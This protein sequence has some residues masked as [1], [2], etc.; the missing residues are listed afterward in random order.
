VDETLSEEERKHLEAVGAW[1]DENTVTV[2]EPNTVT[3]Y[4]FKVDW[5]KWSGSFRIR[6][7]DVLHEDRFQ[8]S[9]DGTG[10]VRLSLP[11]FVSPLGAPASY[12]A[13]EISERTREAIL[14]ALGSTLPK[15]TPHGRNRK[16]G[17]ET[18]V[19]TPISERLTSD[20]LRKIK[21]VVNFK[22]SITQNCN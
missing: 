12:P 11:M 14:Q 6:F 8:F 18:T 9:D 10:K 7:D 19:S 5:S 20:E 21:N 16:T 4:D 13:V 2:P 22:F 17:I 1:L 3:L 15:I